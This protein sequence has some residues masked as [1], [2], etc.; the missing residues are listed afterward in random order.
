MQETAVFSDLG[1]IARKQCIHD[2][3]KTIIRIE[4]SLRIWTQYANSML[5]KKIANISHISKK[6][7]IMAIMNAVWDISDLVVCSK[8]IITKI[9]FLSTQIIFKRMKA[10][11]FFFM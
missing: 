7:Y 5:R 8:E 6:E 11:S 4:H 3:P 10:N 9:T 2:F 1:G